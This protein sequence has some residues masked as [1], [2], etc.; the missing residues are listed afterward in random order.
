MVKQRFEKSHELIISFTEKD[1]R[2]LDDSKLGM[3]QLFDM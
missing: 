1:L 2:I 3:C